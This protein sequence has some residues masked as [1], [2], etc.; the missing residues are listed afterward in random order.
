MRN[1]FKRMNS[2]PDRILDIQFRK[3]YLEINKTEMLR[4]LAFEPDEDLQEEFNPRNLSS[5]YK[6]YADP[7]SLLK[8]IL[9]DN[10]REDRIHK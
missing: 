5:S 9:N 6:F 10:I 8:N 3:K 2:L 4:L 7:K 1:Y